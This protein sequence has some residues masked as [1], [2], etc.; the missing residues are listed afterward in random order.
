MRIRLL[1]LIGRP[2]DQE[3]ASLFERGLAFYERGE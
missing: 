3:F 1:Q 2:V